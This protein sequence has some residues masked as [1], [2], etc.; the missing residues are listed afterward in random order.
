MPTHSFP[1]RTPFHACSLSLSVLIVDVLTSFDDSHKHF[2]T[3]IDCMS[4]LQ[5]VADSCLMSSLNS[6][7]DSPF[8]SRRLLDTEAYM[9]SV[10]SGIVVSVGGLTESLVK[11]SWSALHTH[12][13]VGSSFLSCPL[14]L[15]SL[16]SPLQAI[17]ICF[18]RTPY[19]ER[20]FFSFFSPFHLLLPLLLTERV[21]GSGRNISDS[22]NRNIN[23]GITERACQRGQDDCP[24]V[25]NNPPAAIQRLLGFPATAQIS[26]APAIRLDDPIGDEGLQGRA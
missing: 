20:F 8:L 14:P 13:K 5:F 4:I 12:L 18:A 10:L 9:D 22:K 15:L 6:V 2:P 24:L 11:H 3:R 26:F 7:I 19:G 17:V 1:Q 21:T 16:Q 25:Q 23:T